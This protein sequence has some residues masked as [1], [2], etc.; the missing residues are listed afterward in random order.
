MIHNLALC[1]QKVINMAVK[2]C[3]EP[4]SDDTTLKLFADL[5]TAVEQLLAAQKECERVKKRRDRELVDSTS[6]STEKQK[7]SEK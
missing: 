2:L 4:Y 5:E 1:R 3:T 6:Q 7:S